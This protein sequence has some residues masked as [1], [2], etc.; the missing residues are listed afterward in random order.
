MSPTTVLLA[1]KME[2]VALTALPAIVGT[3]S[4]ILI[5]NVMPVQHYALHV[6]A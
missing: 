1:K 6:Q 3:G 5:K 2:V 4:T